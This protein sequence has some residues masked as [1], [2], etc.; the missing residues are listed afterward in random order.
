[1]VQG[2]HSFGTNMGQVTTGIRAVLRHPLVYETVQFLAGSKGFREFWATQ[3]IRPFPGARIL[4][5]GCGPGEI[6]RHLPHDITYVG[7]DIG[8]EYIEHARSAYG[9]RATF[10]AAAFDE[11]ELARHAPFDIAIVA[12]VLHHLDDDE[13]RNLMALLRRAVPAG[14][15]ITGDIV[16]LPNQDFIMRQIIAWDR[17]RNARTPEGYQAL[18]RPFF[19]D[20]TGQLVR[21]S[22]VVGWMMECR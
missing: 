8:G 21:R 15:V 13:A 2:K 3:L 4:D 14:R 7:Y 18:A 1:M 12:G 22:V 19:S 5:I 17:G 6:L 10:H 9:D 16:V 20:I 11:A